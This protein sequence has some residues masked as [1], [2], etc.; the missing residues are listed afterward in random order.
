MAMI[1]LAFADLS[2]VSLSQDEMVNRSPVDR[3]HD[4]VRDR[5]NPSLQAFLPGEL[6]LKPFSQDEARTA[7]QSIARIETRGLKINDFAVHL[8]KRIQAAL[9]FKHMHGTGL[10]V[11]EDT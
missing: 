10:T 3:F 7:I 4:A 1:P 2:A 6:S 9:E 8:E 5:L 11:S